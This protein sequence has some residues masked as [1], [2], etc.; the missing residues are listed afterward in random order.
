MDR[1]D[2]PQSPVN[3][4]PK[5]LHPEAPTRNDP[6]FTHL[7]IGINALSVTNRSGTGYY[8]QELILALCELDT[9]NEYFLFLPEACLLTGGQRRGE[10]A[11]AESFGRRLRPALRR[12]AN[13]QPLLVSR[14][15]RLARVAW[16][17]YY[18]PREARRLNLDLLHSPTGAA[19]GRLSC[20]AA[21][22]GDDSKTTSLRESSATF[23]ERKATNAEVTFELLSKF[24]IVTSRGDHRV[25]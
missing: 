6:V 5:T 22:L 24:I 13:V 2:G 21:Q 8:T 9:N 25:T 1:K 7:R 16:E 18:L 15:N 20:P 23:A 4:P 17:Q 19:P 3:G 14:R 10:G 11:E 12:A